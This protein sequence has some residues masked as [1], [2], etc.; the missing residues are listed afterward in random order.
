MLPSFVSTDELFRCFHWLVVI[1]LLMLKAHGCKTNT[2][3]KAAGVVHD[4]KNQ[5]C[6]QNMQIAVWKADYCSTGAR[7][8]ARFKGA[9]H[10]KNTYFSSYT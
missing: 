2:I 9:A 6:K 1:R 7:T 3:S 4:C 8:R 10:H 5:K